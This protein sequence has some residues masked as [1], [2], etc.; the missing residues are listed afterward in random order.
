ML[1]TNESVAPANNSDNCSLPEAEA[2]GGDY[3]IEARWLQ[4]SFSRAQY[5]I[6]PLLFVV[7]IVGN[8]M[9]ILTVT[10][11]QFRQLTS[12]YSTIHLRTY[13]RYTVV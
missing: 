4:E 10:K 11:P 1:C 5:V 8:T 7:G 6:C 13:L 9:T 2:G 3:E 12:R